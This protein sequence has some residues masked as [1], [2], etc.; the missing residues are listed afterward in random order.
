MEGDQVVPPL[1]QPCSNMNAEVVLLLGE[2]E[3]TSL[4]ENRFYPMTFLFRRAFEHEKDKSSSSA[5]ENL[6]QTE[7]DHQRADTMPQHHRH[8][9]TTMQQEPSTSSEA[10]KSVEII[11]PSANTPPPSV[12]TLPPLKAHKPNSRDK[13]ISFLGKAFSNTVGSS[14]V[15]FAHVKDDD[16]HVKE[17]DEKLQDPDVIAMVTDF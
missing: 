5:R 14:S 4:N 7:T 9:L 16:E 8:S 17:K 11:V 2:T 15:S 6:D 10:P 12:K 3:L 1:R 13:R